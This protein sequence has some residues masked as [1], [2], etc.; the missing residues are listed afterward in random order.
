MSR[1]SGVHF[2]LVFTSWWANKLRDNYQEKV[3]YWPRSS[4]HL[5]VYSTRENDCEDERE[6]GTQDN[7]GDPFS[8]LICND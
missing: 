8:E 1:D 3:R 5:Q 2:L 6:Y 7:N 4:V